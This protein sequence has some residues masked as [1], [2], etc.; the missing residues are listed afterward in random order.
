MAMAVHAAR[1]GKDKRIIRW[2][3]AT[4]ALGVVFLGIKG[5]EYVIEYHEHLVPGLNYADVSPD[6]KSRPEQD[7]LFMG[8]YF[9]MTGFHALHMLIG[10]G[11][12][13]VMM[14]LAHRGTFTKAYHNP[15]EMAGLY[16]H[17]VDMVWVFLFPTL[18]LLRHAS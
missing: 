4:A 16:W 6:G 8:F 11:V 9:V 2:L 17:F 18:Y 14:W 3:L 1:E 15:L 7:E 13:A 5:T 12:M 10:L